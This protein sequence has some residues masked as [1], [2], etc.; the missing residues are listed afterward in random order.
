MK[1]S[2]NLERRILTVSTSKGER[3][4]RKNDTSMI[5]P[6]AIVVAVAVIGIYIVLAQPSD[7]ITGK[8]IGGNGLPCFFIKTGEQC[9]RYQFPLSEDITPYTGEDFRVECEGVGFSMPLCGQ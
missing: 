2:K 3:M 6:L 8:A 9:A 4:A 1:Q 7:S 5:L